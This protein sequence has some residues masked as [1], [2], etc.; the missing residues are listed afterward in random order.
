MHMKIDS[1]RPIVVSRNLDNLVDEILIDCSMWR[2]V[3]PELT[4]YRVEIKSPVGIT[5]IST[6]TKFEDNVLCWTIEDSDTGVV[7]EGEY[8][9]V[10]TGENGERKTSVPNILKI[11]RII[12]DT[13]S[14]TPPDP[15]K[16]WV[17]KVIEAADRAEAAAERA[18]N[19]GGSGGNGGGGSGKDGESAYEIAVKHGFE[20]SEEEWLESLHGRDGEDGEDGEDGN[21]GVYIGSDRPT[22]PDI[23]VW[24]D[25]DGKAVKVPA[26]DNTLTVPG[27]AADSAVVGQ[28]IA[29]LNEEIEKVTPPENRPYR[30]DYGMISSLT[31][32]FESSWG[33]RLYTPEKVRVFAG[34]IISH[35]ATANSYK[36]AYYIYDQ[37]GRY[38]GESSRWITGDHVLAADGYVRINVSKPDDAKFTDED[39]ASVMDAIRIKRAEI[40]TPAVW[41][42]N[43]IYPDANGNVDLEA[44]VY[45][46]WSVL[47]GKYRNANQFS[48]LSG[49]GA[50]A[51]NNSPIAVK[52][53]GY[54]DNN[55]GADYNFAVAYFDTDKNYIKETGWVTGKRV[56]LEH[57]G[58]ININLRRAD[59]VTLTEDDKT[60]IEE[61][62]K[63][64]P[65]VKLTPNEES[66]AERRADLINSLYIE[67]GRS[68]GAS[69]QFIRIPHITNDGRKVRPV[70]RLTSEDGT[71]DGAKCS[72][73]A[74][75]K[76]EK[77][78]FAVNGGLFDVSTLKPLGQTII[79]GVSVVNERHPQGANNETISDTECYP[80]CIDKDG[81]LSAPYPN[82]VDT[83]TM[84]ADGV[85]QACTGWIKIVED[86]V[87]LD[88]EIAT[89]IVHP[90]P[91]VQQIIGQFFDGDYCI[92]SV[93]SRGYTGSA[94][95]DKGLTYTQCAQLLV[96]KGVKFA[97][98][99]DGGGS[100]QTVVG[101]RLITPNY[102]G[103]SDPTAIVF[104]SN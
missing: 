6:S 9:V 64:V 37:N 71:L 16:P 47:L 62:L 14:E 89:E 102:D 88:D 4:K 53:G 72:I 73:L 42:V 93:A 1:L 51:C 91:Y 94:P 38:T 104:E 33:A 76:R 36:Y 40:N 39:F 55:M 45:A 50:R 8:Q 92:L 18:E 5:Y 41:S 98:A 74:Y 63:I 79:D 96:D 60:Y 46:E 52:C 85:V 31:G 83:A 10:A 28:K 15:S 13:M 30:L 12:S 11:Q 99:L 27:A 25:P 97:Y 84:I 78:A 70:V 68:D 67:Y 82:S 69:W 56:V 26:V 77:T 23:Q 59:N 3:Y 103:R 22:D 17:D 80:L 48:D 29:K 44:I 35:D 54:F 75:A 21:P 57:D 20:G 101:K 49:W 7:G 34:D 86:Y 2:K 24:V 32:E 58:Y 19:A 65:E 100:C 87:V 61:N 90:V 95:N 66:A 81:V 43:G